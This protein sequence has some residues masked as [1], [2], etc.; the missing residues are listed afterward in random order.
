[1]TTKTALVTGGTS[2]IGEEIAR[3]LATIGYRVL[4]CSR[5]G[6]DAGKALAEEIGGAYFQGD[7][8]DPADAEG[9]IRY[10]LDEF[11]RLDVLVNNAAATVRVPWTDLKSNTPEIWHQIL[12]TNVVAPYTLITLAEE[13][14]RASGGCVVNIG[15]LAGIRAVGRSI[16]YGV[17]KAALHHLTTSLAR[18]LAPEV[19][20]NAVAPGYIVTPWTSDA[21]NTSV[22]E[23]FVAATPLQRGGTP[24]EIA[25]VVETMVRASFMT[26]Q[27]VV[28]DG[29]VST[30]TL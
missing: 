15:S 2:G 23:Q 24:T 26:G 19:R 3:R 14:L 30:S 4:I 8:S 1:M 29:G 7:V 18:V 11:G 25:D 5:S 6:P 12:A 28:V 21:E 20:V 13:A 17:S 22:T 27:T 10:A 9:L 16:P